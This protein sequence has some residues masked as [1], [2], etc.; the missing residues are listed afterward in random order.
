MDDYL[1]VNQVYKQ[2]NTDYNIEIGKGRESN[3]FSPLETNI[4]LSG[5]Y[6]GSAPEH[7]S[8]NVVIGVNFLC[9]SF[10]YYQIILLV[11]KCEHIIIDFV[12]FI[13]EFLPIVI[14]S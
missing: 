10:S 6:K 7:D 3:T 5:D 9:A 11:A 12:P 14:D 2:G 1:K 13:L 8:T 4:Y